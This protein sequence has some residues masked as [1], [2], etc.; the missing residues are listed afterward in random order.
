MVAALSDETQRFFDYVTFDLRGGT[1]QDLITKPVAFVNKD[2]APIYGLDASKF[3]ADLT[4]TDLDTS[5]RAG[6]SD[7]RRVPVVLLVVQPHVSRSCGARSSRS[8]F[9]AVRSDRHPRTRPTRR[10]RPTRPW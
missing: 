2:L 3:G 8:R 7:A 10:S 4:L 6:L 9:S 1:F 5:Q